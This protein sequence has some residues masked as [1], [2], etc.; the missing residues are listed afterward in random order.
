MIQ[1]S[2]EAGFSKDERNIRWKRYEKHTCTH[3]YSVH[4]FVLTQRKMR[5]RPV[6]R[7]VFYP[8]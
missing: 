4:T 6:R 8:T 2:P 5:P 1:K 3:P 7:V